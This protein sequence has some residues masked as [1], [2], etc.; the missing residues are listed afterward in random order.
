MPLVTRKQCV[1]C[2]R[3][4]GPFRLVG[5]PILSVGEYA[6]CKP[7]DIYHCSSC[8][9]GR[10][11]ESGF[12]ESKEYFCGRC[13]KKLQHVVPSQMLEVQGYGLYRP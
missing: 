1:E 9:W 8:L 13:H 12:L 5:L 4:T 7:C 6:R 11:Q 2:R 3:T 10:R